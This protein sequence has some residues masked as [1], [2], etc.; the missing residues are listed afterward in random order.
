VGRGK[1]KLRVSVEEELGFWKE[2]SQVS[3][4]R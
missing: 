2:I 1:T 4:A 3:E